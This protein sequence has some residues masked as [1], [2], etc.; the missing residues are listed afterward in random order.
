MSDID[1]TKSESKEATDTPTAATPSVIPPIG[2]P[3]HLLS[4]FTLTMINVAAI[5]TIRDLPAMAV[6]GLSSIFYCVV[7]A[8]VFMIPISL[9]SAEL[10]T[11]WPQRGGVYVWARQA[12]GMPWGFVAIWL[13]WIQNVVWYPMVLTFAA[14]TLAYLIDP[15][16]ANN[17]YYT[18]A[19][20]LALYWSAT[21]VNLRGMKASGRISAIGVIVGTLIP[22]ILVT[23]VGFYWLGSGRPTALRF[24]ASAFVP[25]VAHVRTVV[26]ALGA[27][28]TS[29]VGM[30]MSASHAEEVRS[31][32]RD[33]PRAILFS[34][35][36]IL[37]LAIAGCVGLAAIVPPGQ[38]QP[39]HGFMQAIQ[40]IEA[41]F[42]VD[43][44]VRV[45]AVIVTFGLFAQVT[46]WIPGPSKGLLAVSRHGYL[47]P[48]FHRVNRNNVQVHI[49]LVQ[50][51]IVTVLAFM[52]LVMNMVDA[53]VLLMSIAAELYLVMYI[54]MFAAA[55]RLRYTQPSV[56]RA[57]RVPGP[58][59]VMWFVCLLAICGAVF[60]IAAFYA[61]PKDANPWVHLGALLGGLV[62][63]G[64]APLLIHRLQR[65]SWQTDDDSHLAPDGFRRPSG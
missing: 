6:Y 23:L 5:A 63:L 52:P 20:V 26:L 27:L 58:N 17:P 22:G 15:R 29:F 11:G 54:I 48:F 41:T 3:V 60:S 65:P 47:P 36:M 35:V 38:V 57:Y 24:T 21:L 8:L 31:P 53:Y 2:K 51:G 61:P 49:L 44:L 25:E 56:K 4:V 55:I 7:V 18:V 42:G 50:G 13:Q 45:M 1:N 64:G 39:I 12:F 9:V 33:Y 43:G 46:T 10:A 14:A 62:V 30:E 59:G 40:R 19:M 34:T 37:A 16:L 28:L 32:K